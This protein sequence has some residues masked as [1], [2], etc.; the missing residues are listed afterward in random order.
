MRIIKVSRKFGSGGRE[1]GKRLADIMA[2]DYYER[3][4]LQ[5]LQIAGL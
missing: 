4:Q 2:F 3:Q 5:I 1:L